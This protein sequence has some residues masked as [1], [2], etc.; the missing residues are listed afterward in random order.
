MHLFKQAGAGQRCCTR[1]SIASA[2]SWGW[3]AC[4]LRRAVGCHGQLQGSCMEGL[5]QRQP[6]RWTWPAAADQRKLMA[7]PAALQAAG[8]QAAV[9]AG[10]RALLRQGASSQLHQAAQRACHLP[11]NGS[12]FGLLTSERRPASILCSAAAAL[13]APHQQLI[14]PDKGACTRLAPGVELSQHGG[15]PAGLASRPCG[16]SLRCRAAAS[17]GCCAGQ[18]PCQALPLNGRG[19]IRA[20]PAAHADTAAGHVPV[21]TWA[22]A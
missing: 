20:P 5:R 14:T 19:H 15:A 11:C 22:P 12:D 9:S 16:A 3:L 4:P 10:G 1:V 17:A 8:G 2:R 7:E 13:A 21:M 6:G 18:H